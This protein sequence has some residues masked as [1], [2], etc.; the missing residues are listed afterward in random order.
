MTME[1]NQ[2]SS[3]Y[4]QHE[5]EAT[6]TR[7]ARGLDE[8]NDRL[9]PGQVFDEVLTYAKGGGG[10][11]FRALTNA[12]RENPV[13]SLLIGTGCM[14]FLAEKMGFSG[15][16]RG[17]MFGRSSSRRDGHNGGFNSDYSPGQ[18]RYSQSGSYAERPDDRSGWTQSASNAVRAA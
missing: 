1:D 8:L 15:A 7:L 12:A 2:A 16:G 3:R 14:L 18:N 17:S 10:T 13:P 4:Y 11:F 9:T 6:R 5:A